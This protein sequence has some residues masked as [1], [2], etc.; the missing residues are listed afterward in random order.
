MVLMFAI[1]K[2]FLSELETL[3]VIAQVH[4]GDLA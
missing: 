2:H 3:D 4:L 1:P